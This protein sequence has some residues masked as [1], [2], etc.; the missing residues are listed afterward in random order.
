MRILITGG[1]GFIGSHLAQ[2]LLAQGHHVR[3]IDD[4][5][6]GSRKNLL[7]FADCANL[8]VID[9]DLGIHL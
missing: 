1:S 2:H 6:T 5:S 4:F 9:A 8:E 7:E 3:I